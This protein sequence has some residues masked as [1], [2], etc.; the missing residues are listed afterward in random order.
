MAALRLLQATRRLAAGQPPAS[1]AAAVGLAD[2]AHLTRAFSRRYGVT[3][4]RYAR[5]VG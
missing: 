3:P 5:Q 4:A 2:Q 1:V